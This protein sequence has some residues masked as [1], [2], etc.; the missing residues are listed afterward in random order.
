MNSGKGVGSKANPREYAPA[1]PAGAAVAARAES[2]LLIRL[3]YD[4]MTAAVG[5]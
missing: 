4:S 1:V 5:Y 2:A 3:I